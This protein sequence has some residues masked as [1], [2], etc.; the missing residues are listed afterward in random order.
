MYYTKKNFFILFAFSVVSIIFNIVFTAYTDKYVLA[1]TYVVIFQ[2][3]MLL[4]VVYFYRKSHLDKLICFEF[5]AI[6]FINLIKSI[7]L[8][9]VLL[10]NESRFLVCN[11]L[12]YH[13]N[14]LISVTLLMVA[15]IRFMSKTSKTG[16]G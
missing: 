16:D 9:S 2:S 12:G 14:A 13:I 5:I 7:V 6:H 4:S 1:Q 8:L 3:S 10:F 15:T 11:V